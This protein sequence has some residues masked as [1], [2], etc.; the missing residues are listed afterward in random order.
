MERTLIIR[1]F[2]FLIFSIISP[3]PTVEISSHSWIPPYY[4]HRCAY[5][6]ISSVSWVSQMFPG[7]NYDIHPMSF[8]TSFGQDKSYFQSPSLT[9]NEHLPTWPSPT[10]LSFL[11]M[12]AKRGSEKPPPIPK[13]DMFNRE[14]PGAQPGLQA[15][16]KKP[17]LLPQL[18]YFSSLF[19]FFPIQNTRWVLCHQYWH[20]PNFIDVEYQ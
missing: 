19:L 13:Q 14:P 18:F 3:F 11:T 10:F 9:R 7:Q 20:F 2:S 1:Y 17:H 15:S 5:V 12:T 4:H 6:Q 16:M 8:G